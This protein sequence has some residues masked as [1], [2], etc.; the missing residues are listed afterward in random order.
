MIHGMIALAAPPKSNASAKQAMFRQSAS[1]K[2][3]P[4]AERETFNAARA[5]AATGAGGAVEKM[6]L[7]ARLTRNSRKAPLPAM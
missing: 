7:R 6:K 3:S 2:A 5:A 4:S 1:R